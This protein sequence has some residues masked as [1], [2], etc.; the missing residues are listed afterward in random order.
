MSSSNVW[1]AAKYEDIYIR[2]YG[3]VPELYRGLGRYFAFYFFN[4]ER[5]LQSLDDRTPAAV[6]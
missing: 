6:Y 5:L 2:G 4:D 1:R 3:T